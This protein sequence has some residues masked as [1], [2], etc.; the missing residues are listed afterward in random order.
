VEG[1]TEIVRLILERA[2]DIEETGNLVRCTVPY[3]VSC[4]LCANC[5]CVVYSTLKLVRYSVLGSVLLVQRDV[6]LLCNVG[7]EYA[8]LVMHTMHYRHAV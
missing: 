7:N 2:G 1:H 6:C 8:L 3:N 4:V 5:I